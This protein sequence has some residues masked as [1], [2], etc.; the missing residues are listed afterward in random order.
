MRRVSAERVWVVLLISLTLMVSLGQ[1]ILYAW[2]TPL[3]TV[4]PLVHNF[5]E[6]YYEYLDIMRQGWEGQWLATSRLTPEVYPRMFVSVFL[7]FLGHVA[8]WFHI[9]LP[10]AYT[11]ARVLG[12]AALMTLVY[13]LIRR[14]FPQSRTQRL[15]AFC[16]VLFGTYSWGWSSGGPAVT[17]LTHAWT[18][19]DPVFRWSFVPH[20]LWAKVGMLAVFLLLLQPPSTILHNS[21][22]I[23]LVFV[24]GF[25][26]PVV[27]ATFVPTLA[28]YLLF[29]LARGGLAKLDWRTIGTIGVAGVVL[30]YHRYLQTNIFPWTSYLLWEQTLN[31]KV[32][33]LDY[34][35]SLGPTLILFVLAIP[36]LWHMG[37]VGRL[38]LAWAAT[39]WLML[40][41]LG[42]FVPVTPERYL[43]G[44]Q[45]IPL[46]IGAAVWIFSLKR[47]GLLRLGVVLI[48]LAYFAVGIWASLTEHAG[49]VA[50]NRTNSQV[51]V[52]QE[53][54]AAFTYLS[55]NGKPEDVVMAPYE[56]STMI[57]AFTG[58]RVFAG[59]AMFTKDIE[60]KKVLI[61]DFFAGKNPVLPKDTA[62]VL[63]PS[64]WIPP[65][66]IVLVKRYINKSY[67]IYSR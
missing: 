63:A 53:L 24:M 61:N 30:L 19:L 27:Y 13:Q 8:R 36:T 42:P 34:A 2:G 43:G 52:P 48:L 47:R 50:V 40:Y 62:W 15:I 22:F 57:P 1:T 7:L 59:H 21:L 60:V 46:G 14:T 20:H 32:H 16:F 18:E 9:S 55:R 10:A 11:G 28:L 4:Y 3:G 25:T 26:N 49:Y 23:L 29:S 17:P 66:G 58:R 6:D 39:S 5:V 31:Y 64:P 44:Y 45:F 38:L 41:V 37:K 51:Y 35:M 67:N 33:P 54:M 56:I 12:A 65:Q